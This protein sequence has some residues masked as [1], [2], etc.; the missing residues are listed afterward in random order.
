M[1]RFP[2]DLFLQPG[3]GKRGNAVT[4]H[5]DQRAELLQKLRGGFGFL[6]VLRGDGKLQEERLVMAEGLLLNATE[7]TFCCMRLGFEAGVVY[8]PAGAANAVD[9]MGNIYGEDIGQRDLKK[10]VKKQIS[11][12]E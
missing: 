12:L 8:K 4:D 2:V 10:Y 5:I 3:Y 7:Q 11:E 9:S 6:A 1:Q